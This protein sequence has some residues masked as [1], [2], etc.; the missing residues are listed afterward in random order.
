MD[1]D[2]TME[3]VADIHLPGDSPATISLL[4]VPV[5]TDGPLVPRDTISL[6]V[7][8]DLATIET[9]RDIDL[10]VVTPAIPSSSAEPIALEGLLVA[11]DTTPP[12][13]N[14]DEAMPGT[15]AVMESNADIHLPA[16]STATTPVP[17]ELVTTQDL[18]EAQHARPALTRT[19]AVAE[20]DTTMGMNAGIDLPVDFPV[21][22]PP[23]AEM[24]TAKAPQVAE[25][26]TPHLDMN[27]RDDE[28]TDAEPIGEINREIDL[29]V[30][31]PVTAP[32]SAE[33][34]SPEDHPTAS[35]STPPRLNPS[36]TPATANSKK[37]RRGE[38]APIPK[39][40]PI[41]ILSSDDEVEIISPPKKVLLRA[42]ASSSVLPPSRPGRQGEPSTSINPSSLGTPMAQRI[43][44]ISSSAIARSSNMPTHASPSSSSAAPEPTPIVTPDARKG[45]KK[46]ALFLPSTRK[47][48]E[49]RRTI[50]ALRRIQLAAAGIAEPREGEPTEPTA[51]DTS[52]T[53]VDTSWN[54]EENASS[55]IGTAWDSPAELPTEPV[56][57]AGWGDPSAQP[58][59]NDS[60]WGA[61]AETT[62]TADGWGQ[63]PTM[64]PNVDDGWNNQAAV[65]S[66]TNDGWNTQPVTSSANAGWNT[67]A[68]VTSNT[69]DGW[70][71]Q[72][73]TDANTS[74]TLTT[75]RTTDAQA[76]ASSENVRPETA[77]TASGWGEAPIL[78]SGFNATAQTL[79]KTDGWNAAT[80]TNQ[81]SSNGYSHASAHGSSKDNGWADTTQTSTANDG[82]GLPAPAP[83]N[84]WA[85]RE[86]A[87]VTQPSSAT[88]DPN[89]WEPE[90]ET[91]PAQTDWSVWDTPSAP[92]LSSGW[93]D[94]S[95]NQASG[96][97]NSS[98][99]MPANR[100]RDRDL[101]NS[102]ATNRPGAASG[103]A[104]DALQ[105]PSS[106]PR[107]QVAE[108][109]WQDSELPT[110]TPDTAS[111]VDDSAGWGAWEPSASSVVP[112]DDGW[113]NVTGGATE[114][115][116]SAGGGWNSALRGRPTEIQGDNQNRSFRYGSGT[117]RTSQERVPTGQ[118]FKSA[119]HFSTPS[120]WHDHRAFESTRPAS[121][122]SSSRRHE[123]S[124]SRDRPRDR[125]ADDRRSQ[126]SA[127]ESHCRHNDEST[128]DYRRE[129]RHPERR[130]SDKEESN[131]HSGR[132]ESE[133]RHS[134]EHGSDRSERRHS[135]QR[136]AEEYDRK[137]VR[138][139]RHRSRDQEREHGRDRERDRHQAT[140]RD[141]YDHEHR[142]AYSSR[143]RA[144]SE[145]KRRPSERRDAD[146]RH[147]KRHES[148]RKESRYRE[149]ESSRS[150]RSVP[151]GV[152]AERRHSDT[153]ASDKIHSSRR[154]MG[155][156]YP[157]SR[158]SRGD[159]GDAGSEA[160]KSA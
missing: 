63:P 55:T 39:G 83:A 159:P 158:D 71:T 123:R 105:A 153:R 106:K 30:D 102:A 56:S 127:Q 28:M 94:S 13:N 51:A 20:S 93:A 50:E 22:E 29:P 157:D 58:A 24:V 25:D 10:P 138:W 160:G 7:D 96:S 37:R 142:R 115:G 36:T 107:R 61:S 99:K 74:N 62:T 87:D 156:D 122:T 5:T 124:R 52:A 132:R 141:T 155:F 33:L 103:R 150:E 133:R 104:D 95:A 139:E 112:K 32:S 100:V 80:V 91:A 110:A 109:F 18:L 49:S 54:P 84:D 82:W 118:P 131:R 59:G 114:S 145:L 98:S 151:D 147:P 86:K 111:K 65:T 44:V 45:S 78:N 8:K 42:P 130:G 16:D 35:V 128:S 77:S 75:S 135:G 2:V 89:A 46:G 17:A 3:T 19:D 38:N 108:D 137:S 26:I 60:G 47:A 66:S 68:V 34:V 129:H 116:W 97:W 113:G 88:I 40:A 149:S 126:H 1:T 57:N 69:N 154:A 90:P 144:D 143:D 21:A 15:N 134:R 14:E 120:D 148:R 81:T 92:K 11:Q 67:Q 79:A 31:P 85:T 152:D 119:G 70:N 23:P 41:L 6:L 12:L 125:D 101:S 146:H 73:V 140:D 4:P 27:N 136:E 53:G 121:I 76:N 48:L 43:S 64:T 72:P 117:R 9:D